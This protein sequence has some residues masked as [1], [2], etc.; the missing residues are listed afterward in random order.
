MERS[1]RERPVIDS[2]DAIADAMYSEMAYLPVEQVRVAFLDVGRKLIKVELI[3]TGS[4]RLAH[5]YPREIARRSPP[6][7]RGLAWCS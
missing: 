7:R 4:V 1:A 3:S 2:I 5:I 6:T